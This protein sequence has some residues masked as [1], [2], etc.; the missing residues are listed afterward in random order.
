MRTIRTYVL[1]IKS[2]F[3]KWA[4]VVAK[5][6]SDDAATKL[7]QETICEM[8]SL[9]DFAKDTEPEIYY[10]FKSRIMYVLNG[11]VNDGHLIDDDEVCIYEEEC[12]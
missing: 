1:S 7:L 8:Q 6:I 9:L 10:E 3:M 11:S 12:A 2:L 4:K 5:A